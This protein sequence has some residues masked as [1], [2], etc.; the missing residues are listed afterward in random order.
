MKLQRVVFV[1]VGMM[2]LFASTS[3]AQQ[4]KTDYDRDVNFA[5]YKTYSWEQVKTKLGGKGLD[6][7]GF[8][9][10]RFDRSHGDH[11]QSADLEYV[12]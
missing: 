8:G 5:Q 10:R 1:L 11:T 6:P 2:F 4:V 12:L 3:P 9:R 7:G